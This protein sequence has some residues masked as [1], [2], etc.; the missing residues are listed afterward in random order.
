MQREGDGQVCNRDVAAK[1]LG[2]DRKTLQAWMQGG[3]PNIDKLKGVA[4]KTGIA[5]EDI[6]KAYDEPDLSGE[7]RAC[8]LEYYGK[9]L[10]ATAQDEAAQTAADALDREPAAPPR[11]QIGSG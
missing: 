6:V 5:L 8:L 7:S 3:K 11:D 9:V 2:L 4:R 1:R 10:G